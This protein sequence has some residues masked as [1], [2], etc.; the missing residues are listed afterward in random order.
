MQLTV[1]ERLMI[2]AILP[3]QGGIVELRAAQEVAEAVQLTPAEIAEW[4]VRDE[5][6]G[7]VK[8]NT[9]KAAEVAIELSPAAATLLRKELVAKEASKTLE[10]AHVSLYTKLVEEAQPKE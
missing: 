7:V 6:G 4:E 8:W 1:L 5:D 9:K 3:Q 2:P 10:Q